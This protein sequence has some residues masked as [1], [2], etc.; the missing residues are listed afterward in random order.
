MVREV[1]SNGRGAGKTDALAP[2][3]KTPGTYTDMNERQDP[4]PG[5]CRNLF[6]TDD[7]LALTKKLALGHAVSK[8]SLSNMY[9]SSNF[10]LDAFFEP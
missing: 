3:S 6:G 8:A 9:F 7:Y 4:R 2:G 5:P 10:K 1:L